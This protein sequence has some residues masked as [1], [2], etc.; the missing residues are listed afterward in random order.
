ML[1]QKQQDVLAFAQQDGLFSLSCG[2]VRSGKTFA[3]VMGF[4]LYT[5]SL[6]KQEKHLVLGRKYKVL[7]QEIL[8]HL[9]TCAA[10]ID[11][12]MEYT[13]FN[14][15]LRIGTQ[16]Y[17]VGAGNDVRSVDRIQGMTA[18]SAFVD[19]ITLLPRSSLRWR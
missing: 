1:S 7:E 9:E 18:H 2:S 5:Q 11:L 19:E 3:A 12:P 16:I 13:R 6:A 17:V 10:M 15:M 14:N 8:P 4:L